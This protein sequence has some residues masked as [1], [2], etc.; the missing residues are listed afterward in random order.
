ML[1]SYNRCKLANQQEK[2]LFNERLAVQIGDIIGSMFSKDVNV[3]SIRELFPQL[4]DNLETEEE[5]QE[6][7]WREHMQRMREFTTRHNQ[8]RRNNGFNSR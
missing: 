3:R 4:F 2:A 8:G 6:R 1:N 5:R 7:E